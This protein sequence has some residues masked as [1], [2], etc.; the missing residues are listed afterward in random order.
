MDEMRRRGM[1]RSANNPVADRAERV[2]ADLYGV[3][4]VGGSNKG[5]DL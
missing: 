4:P 5:Y 3:E 1:I 2:V